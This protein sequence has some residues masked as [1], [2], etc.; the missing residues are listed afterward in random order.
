MKMSV[1]VYTEAR[2]LEADIETTNKSVDLEI[3][4]LS[5]YIVK[6]SEIAAFFESSIEFKELKD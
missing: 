2:K 5:D 3:K 4:L 6:H 1:R